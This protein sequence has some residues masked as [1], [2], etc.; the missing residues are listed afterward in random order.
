MAETITIGRDQ[1]LRLR[2]DELLEVVQKASLGGLS[3]QD[4]ELAEVQ[5]RDTLLASALAAA[6]AGRARRRVGEGKYLAVG[7]IGRL[8]LSVVLGPV[9]HL[10]AAGTALSS[11]RR[12]LK[13][14]RDWRPRVVA[15]YVCLDGLDRDVFEAIHAAQ[16]EWLIVNYDAI[17][18]DRYS[19]AFGRVAPTA[20]E[21]TSRL[22]PRADEA[23]V[24]RTLADLVS[25]GILDSDGSQYW[26]RF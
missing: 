8:G 25:R 6:P 17:A 21:V 23:A 2:L 4:V 13:V 26:I 3:P 12:L 5:L 19:E 11:V 24:G 7:A 18:I 15:L 1:G 10:V 16:N 22:I 14:D 9:L 20:A